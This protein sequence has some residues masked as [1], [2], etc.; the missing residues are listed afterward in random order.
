[1]TDLTSLRPARVPG[2][3]LA[4]LCDRLSVP[5]PPGADPGVRLTGATLDSRAVR[6]GDLYAGLRGQRAHGADFGAQ[7][8]AS[9]AAVVLTDDEGAARAAA[10]GLPLVVVQDPRGRL[11]SLA[12]WLYGDPGEHLLLLG[13]TGTNGKTTTTYLLDAAL[14]AAEHTTGLIGTVETRVGDRRVASVRTTPEAP[15]LHAL[16]ALMRE[17][18]VTACAMEVSSHALALHRVDGVVFDVAGFTNLS[19]DHLDFHGTMEDYFAAKAQLFTPAHSRRGVVCVDDEWGRRLAGQAEVPVLTLG[20]A[21]G[22]SADADWRILDP[23]VESDGRT[24]FTLRLASGPALRATSPLPGDFNVVNTALALVMLV[25][26]GVDQESAARGLAA[27][28]AVPGR[29]ERVVVGPSRPEAGDAALPLGVVDYAHTPR[30][31]EAALAA[32]RPAT[33]GRLVVVL[34]AGGDRD[35]G[36]REAM[37][38][39]AA[40]LADVVVVTDDNPRSERP[41]AIRA[42]LLAGARRAA[43]LSGAQVVEVADRGEAVREAVRTAGGPGGTVLVAGKGHEQ[44]QE[45]AGRVHPFDDREVLREALARLLG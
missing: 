3:T 35:A 8:A 38:E 32:L 9:G 11:G 7:A 37:G 23:V 18:G 19:Q 25:E 20:A 43:R 4:E 41:E 28:A 40:R 29:M 42:A 27:S 22:T 36:K 33:K 31:V 44:G 13:V 45:V 21:E 16:L 14:R 6:P 39:T 1:M 17:E 30:A 5:V 2:R 34:G 26:A 10:S 15:D 24:S 12:A